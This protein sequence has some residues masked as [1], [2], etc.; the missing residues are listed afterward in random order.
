[1]HQ[2]RQKLA[3]FGGTF[4]PVHCGHL[5]MAEAALDQFSL[6]QVIWVPTY[7]PS[8][9]ATIDLLPFLHRTEMVKRAIASHPQFSLSTIEQN[10]PTPSYA[11]NTFIGLQAIYPCSEWSWIIG[12]DAFR[13]LLYW[14]RHQELIAQC[15]WLVAPRW[16]SEEWKEVG[17][18]LEWHLLQMPRIEISS[19][20]IRQRCRDRRSIRY[21]VPESVQHYIV[22]NDLYQANSETEEQ[23]TNHKFY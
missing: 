14:H 17:S 10:Q 23:K 12:L 8:Y 4:N 9:K 21:L 13:S 5:L 15:R 6:D 11:I 16:G 19:S 1:M 7:Q 3:I 2:T 22:E 18:D 20:L